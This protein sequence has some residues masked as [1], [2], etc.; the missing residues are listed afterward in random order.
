MPITTIKTWFTTPL[1][2]SHFLA[3]ETE[4]LAFQ[5][6]AIQLALKIAMVALPLLSI[7]DIIILKEK[8]A[9]TTWYVYLFT[10]GLFEV[11]MIFCLDQIQKIPIDQIEDA[12][13]SKKLRRWIMFTVY[14]LTTVQY[15]STFT[16]KVYGAE[17]TSLGLAMSYFN[18]CFFLNT[19]ER[20]FYNIVCILLFFAG[21]LSVMHYNHV[22]FD[23]ILPDTILVTFFL[24][25]FFFL[26]GRQFFH[27]YAEIYIRN[28]QILKNW[29]NQHNDLL[30]SIRSQK[31]VVEVLC[32]ELGISTDS[33][34]D[35]SV[36]SLGYQTKALLLKFAEYKEQLL[37][38]TQRYQDLFMNVNDGVGILSETGFIKEAN[39]TFLHILGIERE[40]MQTFDLGTIVHPDDQE[41][42]NKYLKKLIT[43]GFYKNYV[44]RIIRQN[45][46]A[47]R[48][49]E[50][51]STA[52][53]DEGVY[54]GSRDI[55]R[56]ITHRKIAEQ[57]LEEAHNAE[58]Q[59]LA[60]MSHEIRTPLNAIIGIT[61][62]LYDTKPNP[63]QLEYLDILKNSSQFLLNL[64]T[65]LL[66]FAKMDAG[67]ITAHPKNFDLKGLLKTIQQTFQMKVKNKDL[68]VD[69]IVDMRLE[70]LYYGDETLIYQI[71]FN[72][73]GN[74]DKFT[75]T[76][77]IGLKVKL[78]EK[79]D[80][81]HVFEFQVF[82]TGMGIP[83][84]KVD[85]IFNKFTQIH[86][87]N[88]IKAPG[89]GLGLS[90]CKQIVEFLGGNIWAESVEGKGTKIFFTLR[91]SK[92]RKDLKPV[93]PIATV[94]P[95]KTENNPTNQGFDALQLL[96]VEDN[97]L[98]RKYAGTL[99]NKWQIAYDIAVDGAEAVEKAS[100]KVYDLILMDIQMPVM[101]GYEA[102]IKIMNTDNPNFNTPIIALTA[103]AL[104]SQ[105]ERAL[106]CGMK[107]FL[108]KPFTPTQLSSVIQKYANIK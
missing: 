52:I 85:L 56:D 103:G 1:P 88:K 79:A 95:Q 22:A 48:Y 11:G 69:F 9:P 35:D 16:A 44:G 31:E 105:K 8:F 67:K 30:R 3:F 37:D 6:R 90:I 75:E 26:V 76:G 23:Q 13:V 94:A 19:F 7:G 50:V 33:I 39:D 34:N 91:L 106:E 10:L 68:Q 97:E 40:Q 14:F 28:K 81:E 17:L 20:L 107:D 77:K 36:E 57:K 100:Q 70:H 45:D 2:Q 55:I 65:N 38:S 86:D 87:K 12:T 63:Q 24:S 62:L 82:D 41:N 92:E 46:G 102:T 53:I 43:E 96:L 51:N 29:E 54:K 78:I 71:L 89:T 72:L 61:H 99:L 73:L 80:F 47:V 93:E 49:L 25:I 104:T 15:V 84:N 21:Y 74:A 42:S 66:D 98:N 59:F 5:A 27:W 60:N 4:R 108:S 101:D 83:A 64:I 32:K 18:L 58:K